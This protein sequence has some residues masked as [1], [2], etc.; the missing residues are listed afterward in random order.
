V[1]SESS[2]KLLVFGSTHGAGGLIIIKADFVSEILAR[3]T[4]R[5][6]QF[7]EMLHADADH[8]EPPDRSR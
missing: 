1:G 8:P 4:A 7:E 3:E 6:S 5:L 2:T